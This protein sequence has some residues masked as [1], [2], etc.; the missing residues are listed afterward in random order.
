MEIDYTKMSREALED[1]AAH[2]DRTAF[3]D[4]AASVDAE[5]KRRGRSVD[6]PL[7]VKKASGRPWFAAGT[8]IALLGFI[9]FVVAAS[10]NS[11][12]IVDIGSGLGFGLL[13]WFC[14]A[15]AAVLFIIGESRRNRNRVPP[16]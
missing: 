10:L 1:V 9:P 12:G 14:G 13:L 5:L 15:T 2:I 6:E 8:V 7:R 4:R 16:N 3:P 11:L